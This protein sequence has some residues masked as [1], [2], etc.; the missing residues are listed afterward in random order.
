MRK[1]EYIS[2]LL[3]KIAIKSDEQA[4][5]E[6]FNLFSARLIC[7]SYA[8]SH[9]KELA[10]EVVSD[11]FFKIWLNRKSLDNLE[12]FTAYIFKATKNTTLNHLGTEKR[13]KSKSLEGLDADYV[14]DYICPETS[15]INNEMKLIIEKAVMSLPSRC[16]LIFH[17]AKEEKMR[18]KEIS[19]ILGISVKTIDNQIA[20]A[21]KKI[22]EVIKEYLENNGEI[23]QLPIL[24][25]LFIPIAY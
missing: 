10:E 3:L 6:L 23:D 13:Q 5:K 17:L 12:N 9:N 25:Q 14:I 19:D 24:L 21:I 11:V 4:F 20:I 16:K 8:F 15:L 1:P 22:S 2:Q 18:Y 7:F